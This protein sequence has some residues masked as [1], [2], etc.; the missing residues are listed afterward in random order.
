MPVVFSHAK[1]STCNLQVSRVG[2]SLLNRPFWLN[3]EKFVE[4]YSVDHSETKPSLDFT[5]F[6]SPRRIHGPIW[7]SP[8]P[9]TDAAQH[10]T[11]THARKGVGPQPVPAAPNQAEYQGQSASQGARMWWVWD[12]SL[13]PSHP[14]SPGC[15]AYPASHKRATASNR[16]PFNLIKYW[17]ELQDNLSL[18]F[19]STGN[20]NAKKENYQS[21]TTTQKWVP[22]FWYPKAV[23][24]HRNA[25]QPW[26]PRELCV[27]ETGRRKSILNYVEILHYGPKDTWLD[28]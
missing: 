21:A 20:C 8:W 6:P 27:N 18:D 23:S 17:G 10:C 1:T 5:V 9:K 25:K 13:P 12:P 7:C 15:A 26:L 19:V 2:Y 28:E 16:F 3:L 22:T 11:E 14:L 4:F 24:K